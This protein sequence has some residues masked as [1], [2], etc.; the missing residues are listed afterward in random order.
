MNFLRQKLAGSPEVARIAPFAVYA[1]FS[2]LQGE[3]GPASVYW[4]YIVKTFLAAWMVW[5][6]RPFVQEMRWKLSWE[7]V[8]VGVGIFAIW[9]GLDGH[10]PRLSKL[11]EGT[12]PFKQFGDGSGVAWFYI[13][14]HVA[15]MALIVPPAEEIFYRS[16]VY[17]YL[18]RTNFLEMPLGRFH[19]LSFVVTSAIFGLMHPDRWVAGILCGL[20]YQW[21]VVR[22]GRLGDAMTAHGITN[23]LLGLW[24]VWKAQWSFW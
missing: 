19:G 24:I 8:V 9:V 11:G 6:V 16:L 20:A 14:V 18:V 7:A 3:F 5:Q 23:F 4:L 2:P 12:N 10:Y 22:K 15:G 13:V 21:L 1:V 17:R